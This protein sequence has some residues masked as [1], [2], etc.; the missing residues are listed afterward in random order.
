MDTTG[1]KTRILILGGGFGGAYTAQKLEHLVSH[2]PEVEITLVSQENFILFTPMLHEVAGADVTPADIVQPLRK[3]LRRTNVVIGD[4]ESIDLNAKRVRVAHPSLART[5]DLSYDH[6]V[7]AVG[8]VT[9]F[10]HTPGMAEHAMTMKSLGDA[11]MVRN[12]TIDALEVADNEADEAERRAMLTVVVA[13]G[14]FA[15]VETVGAVN[16]FLREAMKFYRHLKEEMIRI[17]LVHHGEVVLPELGESLGRYAQQKLIERGVE[18]ILKSKVSSFD[19]NVAVISD[20]T[21]VPTHM[22]IWTAGTTPPAALAKLPCKMERGRVLADECMRV[23]DWPGVWALGDCAAVPDVLNPGKFYPP[24]AQHA[25]RQGVVLAGNIMR[26]LHGEA[27]LPFKFKIIGLLATIGRRHGVA[28][29]F[30]L[31]FSGFIAWWMWRGIYLSKLP[32]FPKKVRVAVDWLLDF[33]FAK[34]IVQLRTLQS[35]NISAPEE[36]AQ[37]PSDPAPAAAKPGTT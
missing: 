31:R 14:G 28:Q 19:G 33:L 15:G 5:Y 7:L 3:M 20:G 35:V 27:P 17:V 21:K 9:N 25:C 4:L 23:P 37:H 6:L 11:L 24:T 36:T 29:V 18:I 2:S 8:A 32:G 10:F 26:S 16:D 22:L 1:G 13:G 12:R 34:D 30:G